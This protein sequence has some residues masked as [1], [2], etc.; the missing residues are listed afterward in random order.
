[1]NNK[2]NIAAIQMFVTKNQDKNLETMEEHLDYIHKVFHHIEMVVFPELSS[3]N[4]GASME[5][6]AQKIPGELTEIFSRWAKKFNLW[7]IPGSMYENENNLI[8]NTT[9]IF[10]PDGNIVGKYRKRY[11]WTPYEKTTPGTKPFV[12]EIKGIGK[13]GIMICYDIWFP[14]VARELIHLGAE[15]IIVPTMTTT[16]DRNQEKIIAQAT[17]ITQQCYIISCNG[18]GYGGVGGSQIIDP[19]G[20]ILQDN[21]EGSCMQTAVIDFE[22]VRILRDTGIAGVSTPLK[23]FKQNKQ[24]F[25]TY[26]K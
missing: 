1:M 11:P 8:Y 19:E 15:A 5:K 24:E 21:G 14:E 6:D 18:V 4:I 22:R 20:L 23:A 7:L 25:K 12:F 26:K 10:S 13:I 9:P 2:I 17:A 3:M 16:G